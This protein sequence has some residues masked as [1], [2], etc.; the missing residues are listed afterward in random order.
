VEDIHGKLIRHDVWFLSFA[1][2]PN[3]RYAVVVMVEGGSSG[4]GDCA[5]IA[6]E[7]YEGLRESEALRAARA[8]SLAQMKSE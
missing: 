2:F 3:P 8:A 6:R 5:P 7:I 1:P 4:G